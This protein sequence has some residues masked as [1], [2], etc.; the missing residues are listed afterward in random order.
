Q[1]ATIIGSITSIPAN[2]GKGI[3][4]WFSKIDWKEVAHGVLDLLVNGINGLIDVVFGAA[5]VGVNIVHWFQRQDWGKI[6]KNLISSIG[7][8]MNPDN[9]N[10]VW[11]S[12]VNS[13]DT[14][15]RNARRIV[16]QFMQSVA[17][18]FAVEVNKVLDHL[19]DSSHGWLNFHIDPGPNPLGFAEGGRVL[20]N[21]NQM[22]LVGERGPELVALPGSSYVYNTEK[23][24]DALKGGGHGDSKTVNLTLNVNGGSQSLSANS[25]DELIAETLRVLSDALT[26]NL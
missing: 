26:E 7:A 19:R 3:L 15:F 5:N 2:F 24:I 4:S 23:L 25:K 21:R 6:G 1:W 16:G 10:N 8:A 12:F 20:G 13:A 14:A 22:A 11:T 9:W 18:E 17:H